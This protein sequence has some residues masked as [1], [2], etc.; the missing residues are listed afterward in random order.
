MVGFAQL[1]REQGEVAVLDDGA[2][3]AAALVVRLAREGIAAR[4]VDEV[5]L[6]DALPAVVALGGLR[7]AE[8]LV[9]LKEAFVAARA[10]APVAAER[11]GVFVTVQDTGGDFG[12]AG[13]ERA[14]FGGLAGLAKTAAL[15]W[16][17]AAVKA[18]DLERGGRSPE[19]LAEAITCELLGGGAEVEVGLH[20]DGRRTTPRSVLSAIPS[21]TSLPL[22][23]DSVVVCSGGAR[24]VTAA[25][26][27]A[28][29]Q[30][31]GAKMVLLG[32]TKLGDEPAACADANDE[33]SLKRAL[34]MAAKAAGDKVSPAAIGKQAKRILAQR[35]IRHTLSTLQAQGSPAR[36]LSVDVTDAA[37]VSAALAEVRAEW[38]AI[39]ALVHGAGV[40]ADK[41]IADK[42]DDA[43]DWVVSTKIAGMQALLDATLLRISLAAA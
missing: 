4:V 7:E 6:G 3:V 26:M 25:T 22:D 32:R 19:D 9:A 12:L 5:A 35:E 24:G 28:L 29:A 43:F 15:E 27:I 31:T 13:S 36:Y 16:P 42:T 18:I 17:H 30:R 20:T 23:R 33:P 39:T 37:A 38:G 21:A 14:L 8:P 10:I 34:M 41:L 1:R 11:G 2:G 40:V